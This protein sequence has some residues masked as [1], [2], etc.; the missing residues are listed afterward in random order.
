MASLRMVR[1]KL[2]DIK[3]GYFSNFSKL[4][5]L[6]LG[7][8]GISKLARNE[9]KGLFN[10]QELDL[11]SNQIRS[12]ACDTFDDSP[13]LKILNLAWNH[14]SYL[15]CIKS[16]EGT[17]SL[18]QLNLRGNWL[19]DGHNASVA[20]LLKN[21]KI[22]DVAHNKLKNL[23]FLTQMPSVRL[24]WLNGNKKL[25]INYTDFENSEDLFWVSYGQSDLHVP[26]LF[27]KGKHSLDYID[28][29]KN[30]IDCV[31]IDHISNMDN[32]KILN[33]TNNNIR[34]FP[35][36]G[37]FTPS[38]V[39][40]IHD[41]DF[42]ELR[43]II[44]S[45]NHIYEFPLLPGMPLNSIVRLKYNKL[46]DFPPERLALL[47]KVGILQM[48]HNNATEFPDFSR[49]PGYN[50]TDLD[51]SHN[52]IASVE[53][54]RVDPLLFL[55][56][57]RLQYNFIKYLPISN[58]LQRLVYMDVSH[59]LLETMPC[60]SGVGLDL[61]TLILHHNNLTAVPAECMYG[62]KGL[63]KLDLADNFIASFPF[64]M[65]YAGRFPSIINVNIANNLITHI[66]SLESPW[67]P[68]S[69]EM[70]V[71]SNILNCTYELC[72]LKHFSRFTLHREEKLCASP[73]TFNGIPF[74]DISEVQ[75][76]CF[77][78]YLIQCGT[79]ITRSVFLKII[80]WQYLNDVINLVDW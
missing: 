69:L 55:K 29:G 11:E 56:Y 40:N 71:M 16:T 34:R 64:R 6:S 42:P 31:D 67:I 8:N 73:P 13:K 68:R 46:T 25:L 51:L 75:L 9:M 5:D 58:R 4:E 33:F 76:G 52:K 62:L 22:L 49:A 61:E 59:N 41:I 30:K 2:P 7:S 28:L 24:L 12:I 17:W 66:S 77:R 27:G 78:E 19:T 37:C 14:L 32:M 21:V 10:L 80:L 20:S 38:P 65:I 36:I 35:D 39:S 15:P 44:L 48:Q 63:K 79:V 23:G 1:N 70:N 53:I 18:E 45:F 74:S 43:E 47:K 3:P 60:V 26:P 72:W 54:S 50:M 57:L